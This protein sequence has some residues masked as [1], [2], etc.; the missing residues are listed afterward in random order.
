[1]TEQN[2]QGEPLIS[3]E[4]A[5]SVLQFAD[6]LYKGYPWLYGGGG[7]T[8]D[9]LNANLENLNNDAEIPTYKKVLKA[10]SNAVDNEDTLR[11]FSQYMETFDVLY[12]KV[13]NYKANLLSF[14]LKPV[15]QNAT[16]KDFKSEAYK[17]D[18]AKV[19]T[20][21]RL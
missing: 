18:K 2:Q 1:M 21:P 16:G 20:R 8:P 10:L 17:T 6:A 5:W 3:R 12:E 13:A 15:C 11:S 19:M 14:D 9:I 4:E 7:Y